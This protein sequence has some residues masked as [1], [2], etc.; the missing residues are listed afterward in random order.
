MP[1]TSPTWRWD[2][3]TFEEDTLKAWLWGL[4]ILVAYL[5]V[6]A[7][8][9]FWVHHLRPEEPAA[10]DF[11]DQFAVLCWTLYLLEAFAWHKFFKH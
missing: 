1:S 3:T 2:G 4:R 8:V 11:F 9:I 6:M 7:S 10:W 5:A